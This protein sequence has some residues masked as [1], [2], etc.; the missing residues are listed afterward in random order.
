MRKTKQPNIVVFAALTTTTLFT[1]I[2]FE[3]YQI[4]TK[5][6]L[7]SVPP[8]VLVQLSPTLDKNTLSEI[9]SRTHFGKTARLPQ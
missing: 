2:F 3:A 5:Q 9:E 8:A 7:E 4:L 1:W 6:D